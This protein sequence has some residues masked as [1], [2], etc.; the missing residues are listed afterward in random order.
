MLPLCTVFSYKWGIKLFGQTLCPNRDCN[1]NRT[2]VLRQLD[3]YTFPKRLHRY[4]TYPSFPNTLNLR[5]PCPT[6][7]LLY[8]HREIPPPMLL[9]LRPCSR[10]YWARCR[11]RCAGVFPVQRT[12]SLTKGV[13]IASRDIRASPGMYRLETRQ[14]ESREASQR[15]LKC[16][17]IAS[18]PVIPPTERPVGRTTTSTE[19]ASLPL[20]L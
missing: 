1:Q 9:A 10:R 3:P 8:P 13:V 19:A 4:F 18:T 15:G 16:M 14:R 5:P 17:S 6:F 7:L 2:E 20:A 12:S 11:N